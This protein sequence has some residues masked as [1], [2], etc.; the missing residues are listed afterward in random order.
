[1]AWALLGFAVVTEVFGTLGLRRVADRPT[2]WLITV[3]FIAYTVSFAAMAVSLRTLNVAVVYAIWSAIGT[4]AVAIAGLV[5]FNERLSPPAVVGLFVIVLG[6]A[7][8]M[9]SGSTTHG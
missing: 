3:V 9:Q 4:A 8:L 1:M 6:V 7:I 2:W 5:L